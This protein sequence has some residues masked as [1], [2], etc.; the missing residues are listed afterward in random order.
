MVTER[1]HC[2]L[3][4]ARYSDMP[5]RRLSLQLVCLA[6]L[7][8]IS[9]AGA[10]EAKI[11]YV[12]MK[13]LFSE[14]PQ[15]QLVRDNLDREF[16]PRDEAVGADEQRL[17]QMEQAL[18]EN[19]TLSVSQR[20]ALELDIRNLRRSIQ[21]RR[22]D[23]AEE[24]RFRTTAETN[25]LEKTIALAISEVAKAGGYDLILTSPVAFASDRLDVTNDVLQWLASDATNSDQTP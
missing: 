22:E 16:R 21:R 2:N 4:S 8:C 14:A 13:R 25:A 5:V 1:R 7:V 9:L 23:L 10:Q 11:G 12:D 6:S 24:V 17:A 18:S 20:Q 15:V 19:D 3:V